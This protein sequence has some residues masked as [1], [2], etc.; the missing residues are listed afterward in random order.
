MSPSV[1]TV[2]FQS[3]KGK[4]WR[5]SSARRNFQL[6]A[7]RRKFSRLVKDDYEKCARLTR[8]LAITVK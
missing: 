3:S 5:P 6:T 8:E 7:A 2:R 4:R 1:N